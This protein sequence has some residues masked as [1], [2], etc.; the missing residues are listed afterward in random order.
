MTAAPEQRCRMSGLGKG[1]KI[2][3]YGPYMLTQI[4]PLVVEQ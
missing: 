4:L 1:C 3:A 2:A